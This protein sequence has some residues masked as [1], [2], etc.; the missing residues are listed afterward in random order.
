MLVM[1]L[2]AG[3]RCQ[4]W[5]GT[6]KEAC[7]PF[8]QHQESGFSQPAHLAVTGEWSHTQQVKPDFNDSECTVCASSMLDL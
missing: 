4:P 3:I 7:G 6:N 2:R 5:M 1:K 8:R